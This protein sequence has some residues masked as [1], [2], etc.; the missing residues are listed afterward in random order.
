M[1]GFL[2]KK[3]L[4]SNASLPFVSPEGKV[5]VEGSCRKDR[6][7]RNREKDLL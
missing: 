6:F 1:E 3:E 5:V 2:F 7:Q 4:D